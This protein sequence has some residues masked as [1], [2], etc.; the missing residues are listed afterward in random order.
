[1]VIAESQSAGRGR[2]KRKWVSPSGLNL[3]LTIVLG[4]DIDRSARAG[5]GWATAVCRAVD[6]ATKVRPLI[7]WP[8]DVQV[9]GR[10]LSGVLIESELSGADVR[11]A[12][13]GIGINVNYK[14]A[15]P[16]IVESRRV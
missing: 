1:M 8:N 5:D 10:K 3:S 2:F 9:E 14:I 13:V 16:S 12:L 4:R 7:K 11:Y 6:S 15:G